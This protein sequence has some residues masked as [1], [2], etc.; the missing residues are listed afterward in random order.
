MP[1][2]R[3]AFWNVQ[4][5]F[6]PGPEKKRPRD[7]Q[8]L[9]AKLDV[10]AGAIDS[11]FAGEGPDLLGL[12]EVRA[13]MILERLEQRLQNRYL[14]L[15]ERCHDSNWTGL[16]V[17]ARA[18]S[19]AA[20]SRVDAYRPYTM[21]MPRY[22]IARC[23]RAEGGEPI[24]FVVNHW[25]S[26]LGGADAHSERRETAQHLAEW[27]AGSQ[28]DTCVIVV[29]DFNAEPFE[30]PFGAR[31]LRCVRHFSPELWQGPAPACLYNTA[32]RFLSEPD[33]WEVV[34]A[35]GATYQAPR[36]MT[37]FNGAVPVLLDQLL[38]SGRALRG[39]PI[40][41]QEASVGYPCPGG[42]AAATDGG[43]KRPLPWNE[44]GRGSGASD[45]FPL[46]ARFRI[47]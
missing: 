16:S 28:E 44:A 4:N 33:Y 30:A 34:E 22:L 41:L 1:D 37:T 17:L 24:V 31:G 19:F 10:L 5:L 12:A 38:V 47:N 25:R 26:R 42:I 46:V 13:D 11:L 8:E 43:H 40:T 29:G 27:L 45:H 21:S 20:L 15:F 14:R 2:L 7:E 36:P 3:V 23:E 6:E 18:D 35:R 32:W 39:G 9:D